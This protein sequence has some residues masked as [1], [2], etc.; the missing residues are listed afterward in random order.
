MPMTL[1]RRFPA[2]SSKRVRRR[3]RE[4]P[5]VRTGSGAS[6][7]EGIFIEASKDNI[8]IFGFVRM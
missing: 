3:G 8:T 2:A 6:G 1:P 4:A 7:L 5:T